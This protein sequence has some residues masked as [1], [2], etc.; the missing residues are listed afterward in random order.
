MS[1]KIVLLIS[2]ILIIVIIMLVLIVG[3]Y[4]GYV[5]TQY[6]RLDDELTVEIEKNNTNIV[7]TNN[8]YVI[9]TYN[10][11][12]G[13]YNHDFS[14]FMD[15]GEML[16]GEKVQG[17]LAK[18]VSKEVVETNTSGAIDLIQSHD[19]HFVFIQEIDVSANRSHFINQYASFK[20][21]L[22]DFTAAIAL[23][24]HSAFLYFPFNDPIG[25][26]TAGISTFSKYE[27]SEA[28]RYQL[29]IDNSFPNRFFDLDRC[30]LVTKIK[31]NTDKDLVLINVH[32]SAYDE[33]GLIRALQLE[34][35]KEIMIQEKDNYVIVG[36]DFNHDIGN[37]LNLFATTQKVPN[38]VFVFPNDI[39][40]TG[41]Q[42]VESNNVGTC[43]STDMAYTAGVNYTVVIDGFIINDLISVT[44][45]TNIDNDFVF[46]DHNPVKLTF[47][48]ND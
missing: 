15:S 34:K 33:G 47:G 30:F 12:F 7:D 28:V 45:V 32:L 5:T 37:S 11:G 14:F 18:A 36:G 27:I 48:F 39:L 3:G 10:I 44:S 40:P 9:M 35:L 43:R 16:T 17:T 38:W 4:V 26:T 20:D 24:F 13:A 2:K 31:T 19:P 41:Y 46:S 25:K 42:I 22:T 21:E 1:K 8:D 6:Y 29:P 23:N